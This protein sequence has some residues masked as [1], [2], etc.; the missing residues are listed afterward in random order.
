S[1]DTFQAILDERSKS[2]QAVFT[3]LQMVHADLAGFF[4]KVPAVLP[5]KL[6]GE[7]LL[8]NGA[9]AVRVAVTAEKPELVDGASWPNPRTVTNS[10]GMFTLEL[11]KVPM[12]STGLTLT[13]RGQNASE[14]VGL[15]MV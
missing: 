11:P 3:T 6:V 8:D 2:L 12:P 13:I 10:L 4:P 9:P 7:V 15:T 1:N 5:Q 14:S